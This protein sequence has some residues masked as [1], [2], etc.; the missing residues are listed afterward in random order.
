MRSTTDSAEGDSR[1][2]AEVKAME[3]AFR[4]Q[5][6]SITTLDINREPQSVREMYGDTH[7]GRAA[8]LAR[9]LIEAGVRVVAR[10][11]YSGGSSTLGYPSRTRT[12]TPGVVFPLSIAQPPL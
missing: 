7:F 8:L 3:T 10:L 5:R 6:E 9:R 4:M 2:D 11:Q 1:L 12:A